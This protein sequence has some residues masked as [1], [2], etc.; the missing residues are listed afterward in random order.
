MLIGM[1]EP[2]P[3]FERYYKEAIDAAILRQQQEAESRRQPQTELL[4]GGDLSTEEMEGMEVD[5]ASE[6]SSLNGDDPMEMDIDTPGSEEASSSE[7]TKGLLRGGIGSDG[8][9]DSD[10]SDNVQIDAS[11]DFVRSIFHEI[12]QHEITGPDPAR[13]ARWLGEDIAPTSIGVASKAVKAEWIPLYGYQGAVWFQANVLNSFIDAVDRLLGLDNRAGVTYNLYTFDRSQNYQD[14]RVRMQWTTDRNVN[15]LTVTTK[16]V[17]DYSS[18]HHA[19]SWAAAALGV[20]AKDHPSE[21]G[22]KI[23]FVAGPDDSVPWTWEPL[24]QHRILK[25]AL[26]WATDYSQERP[27]LAYLRMPENPRSASWTNQ[28]GRY[29]AQAARVLTPSR[30]PNRPGQPPIPDAFYGLEGS[31]NKAATYGAL[32][33]L[34]KL[35]EEIVARWEEDNDTVVY[36]EAYGYKEKAGGPLKVSDRWHLY[37]PGL[38]VPY[39]AKLGVRTKGQYILHSDL[40]NVTTVQDRI[41]G[42]LRNLWSDSGDLQIRSLE[43]YL[44]GSGF[45]FVSDE[46]TDLVIDL[47]KR[48]DEDVEAA[49]EPLVARLTEWKTWLQEMPGV[50]PIE[51]GL[52]LFPQFLTLRPVYKQYTMRDIDSPGSKIIWDLQDTDL[53]GFRRLVSKVWSKGRHKKPYIPGTSWI[54]IHQ[55]HQ[56]KTDKNKTTRGRDPNYFK[57]IASR[58]ES[59]PKLIVSPF[60]DEDEWEQ[61]RKLIV[62][63]DIAIS[64]TD[65]TTQPAFGDQDHDQPFGLRNIYETDSTKLYRNLDQNDLPPYTHHNDYQLWKQ[66]A[67]DR[68]PTR[69][70]W[71]KQLG[72]ALKPDSAIK[73]VPEEY[74]LVI[75]Q[76]EIDRAVAARQDQGV[77]QAPVLAKYV[78]T[79]NPGTAERAVYDSYRTRV[80]LKAEYLAQQPGSIATYPRGPQMREVSYTQPLSVQTN[81]AIPMNAPPVEPLLNLGSSSLPIVSLSVLTPTEVR[82]LQTHFTHMRNMLLSRSER[83]PYENCTAVLPLRDPGVM[84]AHL[85]DVHSNFRCPWCEEQLF[86]HWTNAD[87]REHIQLH[88][89]EEAGIKKHGEGGGDDHDDDEDDEGGAD[90]GDVTDQQRAGDLARHRREMERARAA[91]AAARELAQSA[92]RRAQHTEKEQAAL[93][94]A[95]DLATEPQRRHAADPGDTTPRTLRLA[96]RE[97]KAFRNYYA[98]RMPPARRILEALEALREHNNEEGARRLEYLKARVNVRAILA[99]ANPGY[100]A[101][102]RVRR[103]ALVQARNRII[104]VAAAVRN[105]TRLDDLAITEAR[106]TIAELE[107]ASGQCATELTRLERMAADKNIHVRP[108]DVPVTSG[109]DP[110]PPP[111][112]PTT[113]PDSPPP[114]PPPTAGPDPKPPPPPPVTTSGSTNVSRPQ[115]PTDGHLI[116]TDLLRDSPRDE[117]GKSIDPN[118]Q[119]PS[120]PRS[121]ST[122]FFRSRFFCT[123]F[124]M[125]T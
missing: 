79:R 51:N 82:R 4:R 83:C 52:G 23:L 100:D 109:P 46:P 125:M 33:F 98:L 62:D 76:G 9:P 21:R 19:W 40:D 43:V 67:A 58:G 31:K 12:F 22:D 26:S 6:I 119:S 111:P 97:Q 101:E 37:F 87:R 27:D 123:F 105:R 104:R 38:G 18:D 118:Q 113:R 110:P 102:G 89:D 77:T 60:I 73:P 70:P 84:R 108:D 115:T 55:G 92:R 66:D 75:P 72:A 17:G 57:R 65:S 42:L 44:P 117:H 63:P 13:A 41:L 85:R 78:S 7:S 99:D 124:S 112:P 106:N 86:E 81:Q 64:L 5:G 3:L 32:S 116:N 35:W 49:F 122:C 107:A 24:P 14:K 29:I 45:F 121:V 48:D 68:L 50:P 10:D 103:L 59:K 69:Q 93:Q 28:Y 56:G 114:P 39:T 95:L 20:R 90:E 88:L 54:G 47:E 53:E 8:L 80:N 61:I 1:I 30:V 15:G 16:G 94:T 74:S 36:L 34:P 11:A 91:R 25:V 96:I 120:H 71:D 2:D